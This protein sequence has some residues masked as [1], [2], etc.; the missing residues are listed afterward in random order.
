MGVLGR[1]EVIKEGSKDVTKG[2][3]FGDGE[4]SMTHVKPLCLSGLNCEVLDV[5]LAV[6]LIAVCLTIINRG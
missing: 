4:T 1:C 6:F 3:A 5:R 2:L